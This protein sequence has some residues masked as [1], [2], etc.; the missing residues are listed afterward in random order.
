ME[1]LMEQATSF[2]ETN[3]L[4]ELCKNGRLFEV[5]EWITAGKPINPPL[6]TTG[7]GPRIPLQ[8][9]IDKGFHSLVKVLVQNGA[10]CIDN[11]Y[12]ALGHALQTRRFDLIKLLIE[13]GVDVHSVEMFNVFHTWDPEIM[14]YFIEKGADL[15]KGYPLAW[16]LCD[17]IRSALG[18]VKRHQNR[19]PSFQEQINIALR[20][21]C[22]EGNLKWVSLMLWAGADPFSKGPGTPEE[23]SDPEEDLCALEYAA[24][25]RHIEIFDLKQIKISPE[26]P[27]SGKI[28]E[29]ACWVDNAGFLLKLIKNGIEPSNQNDNG[30]SLIQRCLSHLQ[31]TGR[32]S[33][34]GSSRKNEIDNS[35]SRETLKI[36]HILVKHGA[37]W[38]P[39]DNHQINDARRSL[40]KMTADYTI[41]FIWIMATYRACDKD[42]ILQLI[43]TPTI[44]RHIHQYQ[45]R[46]DELIENLESNGSN[47]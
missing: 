35:E 27:I 10:I 38:T 2:E 34:H 20:Y 5:Q 12:N 31:Y 16:A 18:V 21:H 43:R 4:A 9:A 29:Y 45:S 17:K 24:L 37:K 7:R 8:I 33:W 39:E 3:P 32:F 23:E 28:L 22:K 40:L 42:A 14:E 44:K 1:P 26:N 41:E 19:F 30:S 13:H 6:V 36:I 46:I 11:N 25:Y 15:E 47:Q